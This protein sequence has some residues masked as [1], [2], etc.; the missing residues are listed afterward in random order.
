[1]ADCWRC[2]PALTPHR[3]LCPTC[4]QV[5]TFT[6][7][8]RLVIRKPGQVCIVELKQPQSFAQFVLGAETEAGS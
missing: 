1:M 7:S 4:R 2:G 6:P 3:W 5:Y 8:G